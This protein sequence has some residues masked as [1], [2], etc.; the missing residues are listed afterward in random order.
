[1]HPL[2]PWYF[3][4]SNDASREKRPK[5]IV[6]DDIR[7]SLFVLEQ[8]IKNFA[9]VSLSVSARVCSKVAVSRDSPTPLLTT[10]CDMCKCVSRV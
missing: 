10:V 2:R 6:A 3:V 5:R 9:N 7:K 4:L 8:T 1:M